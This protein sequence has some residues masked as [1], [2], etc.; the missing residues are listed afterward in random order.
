MLARAKMVEECNR[1]SGKADEGVG[2]RSCSCYSSKI[3]IPIRFVTSAADLS[4]CPAD[5]KLEIALLGRSNAGKSSFINALGGSGKLAQVSS[6][7][8]KTRLLNFFEVQKDYRLVDMPGYGWSARGGDEHMGFRTMIEAYLSSR[9]NLIGLLLIMD[10]R[11]DWSKDEEELKAWLAPRKLPIVIVLT[12]AD[13]MSRGESLQRIKAIKK[14]SGIEH[15][16]AISSSKKEGLKEFEEVMFR[17]LL[18]PHKGPKET[19]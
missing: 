2:Q 18:E 17:T 8:G 19:N 7:P 13:K 16:V 15:V 4:G 3:V 10:I 9:A 5:E 1:I 11:R 12:K 14:T 6:T